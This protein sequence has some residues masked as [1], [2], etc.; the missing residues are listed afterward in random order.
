[1]E[2]SPVIIGQRES[3]GVRETVLYTAL[4]L[5]VTGGAIY[6][7][8]KVILN[9]L[10]N[11]EER[12]SMEEGSSA[13]F[14]KRIRMAFD[15]DGWM[16][17]DKEALRQAMRQIPSKEVFAQ[18]ITSYQ[19]LYTGSLLKDMSDELT[20]SEYNEMMQILAGKPDKISKGGKVVMNYAAWARRLKAAFDKMYGF[21]PGTDEAAIKAVFI[22]IPTH[23][24]FINVGTA[25]F[26][27]F[28]KNL[29]DALKGELSA[30]EYT[31]IMRL[32]I[33]KP[34]K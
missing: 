13:A 34:Q 28:G 9:L 12:K 24:A 30:T 15:N 21:V 23:A 11:S 20:S 1:M 25:Y 3:M 33:R 2:N 14:A 8:R 6:F 16:G 17:T 18:V 29:I 7:G 32:I 31:E 5:I 10:S 19:K 27:E 26:K 4:G 22:E